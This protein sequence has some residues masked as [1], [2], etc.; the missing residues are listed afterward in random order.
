[1]RKTREHAG[2]RPGKVGHLI[3]PNGDTH[4]L[5]GGQVAVGVEQQR[6]NLRAQALQRVLRERYA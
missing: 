3:R 6:G 1:M 4:G 5:V 2:E